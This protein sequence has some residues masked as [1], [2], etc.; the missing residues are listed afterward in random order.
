MDSGVHASL[1]LNFCHQ[2]INA[3]LN[4]K[5]EY[6]PLHE[7]L[8]WDFKRTNIQLL[9]RA[10][11]TINPEKLLHNKNVNEQLYLFNKTMLNIFHNF[12]PNKNIIC[13]HKDSSD[14]N[15]QIKGLIEQKNHL[16]K[17]YMADARLAVD[18]AKLQ[19]AGAELIKVIKFSKENFYISHA[20]KLNDPSTS[21]KTHWSIMKAF[22]NGKKTQLSL[23]YWSATT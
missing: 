10:I 22:I 4:L 1:H 16:F 13:Y 23:H 20:K 8:V 15:N 21:N 9:N 17:N 2:I 18:R 11:E 12:I 5:T 6:Q 14:F 3:K 19:K 7:Q